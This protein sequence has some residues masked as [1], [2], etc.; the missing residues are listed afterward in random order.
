MEGFVFNDYCFQCQRTVEHR[1][2]L[3]GDGLFGACSSCREK[4]PLTEVKQVHYQ[5]TDL[6]VTR[7][8]IGN[9]PSVVAG[10]LLDTVRHTRPA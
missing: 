4:H 10:K 6:W 2:L 9:L 8:K 1:I 3:E 5:N 7:F